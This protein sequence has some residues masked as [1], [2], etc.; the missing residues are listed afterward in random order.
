MDL[1][2]Q[3]ADVLQPAISEEFEHLS[4]PIV[5]LLAV[6]A[7]LMRLYVL[8]EHAVR[9]ARDDDND[10][11]LPLGFQGVTR[12]LAEHDGLGAV[13]VQV[14]RDD[15]RRNAVVR[16]QQAERDHRAGVDGEA[17]VG[18]S[19]GE[20][21]PRFGGVSVAFGEL[22]IH[23]ELVG[24]AAEEVEVVVDVHPFRLRVRLDLVTDDRRPGGR[25]D[26]QDVRT[27]EFDLLSAVV[28]RCAQSAP[29]LVLFGRQ[30][31]LRVRRHMH[32]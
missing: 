15:A 25:V 11:L 32:P 12:R 16:I 31:R 4:V 1:P 30:Q 2:T 27:A 13:G 17:V 9:Q 21:S 19:P 8:C 28:E 24:H 3:L 7:V 10:R 29:A 5:V 23:A 26:Q 18:D 6:D 22:D 20:E 14:A